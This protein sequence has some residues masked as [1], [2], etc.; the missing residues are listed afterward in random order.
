MN[1]L[2]AHL[3]PR[4]YTPRQTGTQKRHGSTP[5]TMLLPGSASRS[6]VSILKARPRPW[7]RSASRPP[8]WCSSPAAMA[9]SP[10]NTLSEVVSAHRSRGCESRQSRVCRN[11][12]GRFPR[13]SRPAP[14]SRPQRPRRRQQQS[15]SRDREL[16][17]AL[18][19][20]SRKGRR[21]SRHRCEV[22]SPIYLRLYHR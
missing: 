11:V 9:C 22:R 5:S 18:A 20:Q 1:F 2:D 16:H 19:R 21:T 6:R 10:W 14:H 7:S 12:F 13:R 15:W 3:Q 4:S 17:P 8:T